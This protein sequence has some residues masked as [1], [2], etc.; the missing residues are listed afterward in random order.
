MWDPRESGGSM[1]SFIASTATG[2]APTGSIEYETIFAVG[3]TL[4][5]LTFILNAISIR[6]VRRYR[7]VYE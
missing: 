4:F 3:M 5:V 1:A 7:Q 6:L 2:D